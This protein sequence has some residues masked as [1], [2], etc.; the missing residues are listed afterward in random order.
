[1]RAVKKM[2]IL[3]SGLE[4]VESSGSKFLYTVPGELSMDQTLLIKQ[5]Y[6]YIKYKFKSLIHDLNIY[7]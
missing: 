3:G 6:L 4:I 2:A 5:V 7:I 1:M